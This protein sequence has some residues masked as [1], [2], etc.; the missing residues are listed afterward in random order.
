MTYHDAIE[1]FGTQVKLARAL[2]I[3]Q[4]TVSCWRGV[5]PAQYQYQLE[6]ITRGRL[7]ADDE[8]RQPRIAA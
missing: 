7:R 4:P 2:G 1:H 8:L 5:V 6:V 3:S